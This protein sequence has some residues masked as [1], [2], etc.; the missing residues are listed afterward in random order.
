MTAPIDAREVEPRVLAF[1]EALKAAEPEEWCSPPGLGLMR[2]RHMREGLERKVVV[3]E[4][5]GRGFTLVWWP[6][7]KAGCWSC[8]S[9]RWYREMLEEDHRGGV[10]GPEARERF[11]REFQRLLRSHEAGL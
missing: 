2:V 1:L 9:C 8:P 6:A 7:H 10:A 5:G 11:R 3:L 4:H